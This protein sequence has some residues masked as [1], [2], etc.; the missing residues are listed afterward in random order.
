MEKAIATAMEMKRIL[1]LHFVGVVVLNP[2]FK[3]KALFVMYKDPF[4]FS[5]LK[6]KS[7]IIF[8]FSY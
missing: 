8:H 2:S 5:F 6:I 4:C 3:D 1:S 7:K